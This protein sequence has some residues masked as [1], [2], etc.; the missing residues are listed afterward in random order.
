VVLR[1]GGVTRLERIWRQAATK[2]G[3]HIVQLQLSSDE[4]G[5]PNDDDVEQRV[6]QNPWQT[7]V[8][9]Q[10]NKEGRPSEI[11]ELT[12]QSQLQR[13]TRT[14]RPNPKYANTAI[15]EEATIIEPEKFKEVS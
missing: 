2:V 13:S 12:P 11:K 7:S 8:Y 3:E 15:V 4:S 6:T 10:P 9:Q 14:R 1:E 5:D